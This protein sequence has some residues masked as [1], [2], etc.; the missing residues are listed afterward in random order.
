[1]KKIIALL[2]LISLNGNF[3]L[4]LADDTSTGSSFVAEQSNPDLIDN[5]DISVPI[6]EDT[7]TSSDDS[8]ETPVVQTKTLNEKI[9]D[10]IKNKTPVKEVKSTPIKAVVKK[11]SSNG[12]IL[13]NFKNREKS[14]LFSNEVIFSG[15]SLDLLNT[16]KKMDIFSRIK[17]KIAENRSQAE[18]ENEVLTKR[19]ESLSGA[20]F[21]IDSD[22]SDTEDTIRKTTIDIITTTNDI[23]DT[24]TEIENI[25]QKVEANKKIILE[26]LVHLYKTG[27]LVYDEGKLDSIR[28]ILLS[29][30]GDL[31][32]VLSDYY[33][34]SVIEVTGQELIAKHRSLIKDLFLKKKDLEN[35]KE[36]LAALRNEQLVQKTTLLQKKALRQKILDI[37]QG[38]SDK[39]VEYIKEKLE[40]EKSVSLK[41]LQQKITYKNIKEDFLKDNKCP[42]VDLETGDITGDVSDRC[43]ELSIVIKNEAALGTLEKDKSGNSFS[44][45]IA[46]TKGISAFFHD[47][48]YFKAL[49]SEHEAIDI[50][51]PQG[52]DIVAPADGYVVY[53]NPPVDGGYAYVALKHA[54]GFLTVYGH[55]S[56]T[57]VKKYDFIKA[58]EVFAKSGGSKGTN[59]AGPMTSGPH[60]HFEMIKDKDFVDPLNYLDLTKLGLGKLPDSK[61]IYKYARDFKA[62]YGYNL[63]NVD[64]YSKNTFVLNGNSEVD[65]QKDLLSKYASP[66][67]SDWN[68]WVEESLDANLDPSFVMCIG[69]AETGLGRHLKSGYNVGNVGNTDSGDV[70]IFGG[71]RAGIDWM[72]RTLNNKYLGKY[73]AVSMLSR[74]GNNSGPIY[75]SSPINWHNNIIRC[76]SALKG[77][78][79][80]DDYN[81]RLR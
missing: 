79:I 75:A 7:S 40:A 37:T 47:P 46:P 71:A 58:G 59:G 63:S 33:F 2:I 39:Y 42:R 23:S 25:R 76:M 10:A 15:S 64:S 8:S 11:T 21:D 14:L 9:I 68:I 17:E 30:D 53:I 16:G 66:I 80:P 36:S 50:R 27:N 20:I 81:F 55:I 44:W 51:A 3:A 32:D 54:D 65:R 45:P 74:Y 56:E 1:M 26:Y 34:K 69:L 78:S 18:T 48:E 5:T 52:T 70:R 49:G 73:N 4:A 12:K 35:K 6:N 19:I 61:Y 67:F 41:I 38:N 31:G 72:T 28:T 43:R 22:I 29:G 60:L 77:K 13:D 57:D 62:T 24:E